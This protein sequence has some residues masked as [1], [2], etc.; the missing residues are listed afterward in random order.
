YS[1]NDHRYRF[2]GSLYNPDYPEYGE[3]I[4]LVGENFITYQA[5]HLVQPDLYPLSLSISP[6]SYNADRTLVN[7]RLDISI[8]NNLF[9]DATCAQVWVYD[10]DPNDGG[11]LITGP[12][13]ASMVEADYGNGRLTAYW[14]GVQPLTEHTLYVQVEPIGVSDTNPGNNQANFSVY[15]ELPNLTFLSTIRR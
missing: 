14:V 9:E 1:L 15:L 8:G 10:G 12:L 11:I 7:Y 13:P 5:E 6:K 4:T 3:F 2:G